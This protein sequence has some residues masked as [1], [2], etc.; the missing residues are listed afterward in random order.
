LR[1]VNPRMAN[2]AAGPKLLTQ[3]RYEGQGW[4]EFGSPLIRV[5]GP[6]LVETDEC[7]R[8]IAMMQVQEVPTS[9][10][11][12]T[13]T[14][15]FQDFIE[16][17]NKGENTCTLRVNTPVGIFT[18][19]EM[20]YRSPSIAETTTVQF[21]CH[22]AQFSTSNSHAKYWRLPIL[23]FHGKLQ[24]AVRDR[25]LAHPL[26]VSA[27]L[28]ITRFTMGSEIG[29]V[30]NVP[31][32]EELVESQGKG[33]RTPHITA[34]LV[35]PVCGGISSWSEIRDW[36]PFGMLNLLG[37]SSGSRVGAPW[38]EFY[39]ENG[40]LAQRS[41]IQLGTSLYEVGDEFIND[42]IHSGGLGE[43]ITCALN[44]NEFDQAYITIA[45]NHLILGN[46]YSQALEDKVG[47]FC[48]ALDSLASHF[49]F[50]VQNLLD[51]IGEEDKAEVRNIL[52]DAREKIRKL[53][54]KRKEGGESQIASTLDRIAER[55]AATPATTDR[56]FGLAVL[57]LIKRFQMH[58]AA[59]AGAY[60]AAHP[61]GDGRS[62]AALLSHYRGLSL[63]G[64]AFRFEPGEDSPVEVFRFAN[65]LGDIVIRIVL[66]ILGYRGEYQDKNAKWADS[67]SLDWVTPDT[68]AIQLGFGR[69]D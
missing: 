63:H 25:Y 22:R 4:A 18:A 13:H 39:D 51:G 48:R 32:Y 45:L 61:R 57:D 68:P 52:R 42:I 46:R 26:R 54:T 23:N 14:R 49:G 11:A 27:T 10:V 24:P 28:P 16:T 56:N 5:E 36:F 58:D 15:L 41:H 34:A 20:V 31:E 60:Y 9:S 47:H 59:V 43:L 33:D 44:S 6:T 17:I 40:A 66:K 29:F 55:A 12:D 37:L 67:R 69:P 1:A 53:A 3:I 7:G 64:G 30:E 8:T 35:G 19:N 50:D 21:Q 2:P 62:W 38:V 65:H